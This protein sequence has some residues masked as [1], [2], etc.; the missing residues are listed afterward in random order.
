M[1]K[2]YNL[3]IKIHPL[4]DYQIKDKLES[5]GRI[6]VFKNSNTFDLI[7][8]AKF[9]FATTSHSAYQALVFFRKFVFFYGF[10]LFIF[11]KNNFKNMEILN[12]K[13][14]KRRFNECI[15]NSNNIDHNEIDRFIFNL[16]ENQYKWNLSA[17]SYLTRIKHTN[18]GY[19]NERI[20][21]NLF[22][23]LIK[24]Y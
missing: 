18:Y 3:I 23:H 5:Y 11:G 17:K 22:N 24:N 19:D 14:N 2:N 13:M 6:Y 21:L 1:P 20:K 7:R 4:D 10:D 12:S 16:Y 8:S 15:K 9:I